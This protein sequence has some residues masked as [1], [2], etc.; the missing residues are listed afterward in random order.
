MNKNQI[1]GGERVI[2]STFPQ[3]FTK[4]NGIKPGSL[5]KPAV[6]RGSSKPAASTGSLKTAA[7]AA[8]VTALTPEQIA[9]EILLSSRTFKEPRITFEERLLLEPPCGS[10]KPATQ[11]I[12]S[13][14]EAANRVFGQHPAEQQ[15]FKVFKPVVNPQ[16]QK[17]I[18]GAIASSTSASCIESGP[19]APSTPKPCAESGPAAPSTPKPCSK[20]RPTALSPSFYNSLFYDIPASREIIIEERAKTSAPFPQQK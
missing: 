17:S 4:P 13:Q 3:T 18:P 12:L 8:P 1:N 10:K 6:S 14:S 15:R 7:S 20:P 19:V 2:P 16:P 5:S 9:E 11:E